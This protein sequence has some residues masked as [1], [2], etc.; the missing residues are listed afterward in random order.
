MADGLNS[1]GSRRLDS[2]RARRR[3][4]EYATAGHAS[5]DALHDLLFHSTPVDGRANISLSPS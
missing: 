4:L 3:C 1:T 2:Q 5:D